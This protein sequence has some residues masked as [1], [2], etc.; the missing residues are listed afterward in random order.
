M[1]GDVGPGSWRLGRMASERSARRCRSP[2]EAS[3]SMSSSTVC[4]H[5]SRALAAA[6]ACSYDAKLPASRAARRNK[7]VDGGHRDELWSLGVRWCAVAA[8]NSHTKRPKSAH[9]EKA[10]D[11]CRAAQDSVSLRWMDSTCWLRKSGTLSS[12]G[13]PFQVGS[14][15]RDGR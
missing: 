1:S 8:G 11:M 9:H 7:T 6:S 15:V 3:A 12:L 13:A 5:A 14:T 10:R 2:M 4:E